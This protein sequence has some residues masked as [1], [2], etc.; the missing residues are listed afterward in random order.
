MART[1][2]DPI[3]CVKDCHGMVREAIQNEVQLVLSAIKIHCVP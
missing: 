1:L 3:G 2:P